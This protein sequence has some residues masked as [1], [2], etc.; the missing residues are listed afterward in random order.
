MIGHDEFVKSFVKECNKKKSYGL[1]FVPGKLK[2]WGCKKAAE[3]AWKQHEKNAPEKPKRKG[4]LGKIK[5]K[6]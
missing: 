1:K 4:V 2:S 3:R 6:W 5:L